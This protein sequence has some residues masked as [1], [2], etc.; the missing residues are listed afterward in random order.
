MLNIKKSAIKEEGRK[1]EKDGRGGRKGSSR[2][3]G[4]PS[5]AVEGYKQPG[6]LARPGKSRCLRKSKG[7]GKQGWDSRSN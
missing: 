4:R 7:H 6:G 5:I 1:K 2:I 3:T